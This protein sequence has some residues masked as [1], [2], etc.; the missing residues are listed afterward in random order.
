MVT[1][2]QFT[3]NPILEHTY[4]VSDE[5]GE[6]VIVDPGCLSG[7]EREAVGAYIA[8]ANL[9]PVAIWFTHLHFDH[10]WGARHFVDRY[11]IPTYASAA[12][13]PW[14]MRNAELTS[15]WGLPAPDD[16]A[17]DNQLTDGQTLRFGN[18]EAT[19]LATPGHSAGGVCYLFASDGVC[20]TGDTLFCGS[21]GRT[22]FPDGNPSAIV[23]SVRQ[24]L[25]TLPADTRVLPGHGPDSTVEREML[26][27]PYAAG[28]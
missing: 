20:L 19:V 27:N 15:Q 23:A 16:F 1:V 13:I 11:S 4:V 5:S 7:G 21:V 18:T 24:K 2:K 6:C 9:K 12:D 25:L 28:L 3:V 10:V 22:D 8:G 26:Y 14:L 17:I